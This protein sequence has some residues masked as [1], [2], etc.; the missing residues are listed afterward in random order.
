MSGARRETL[1]TMRRRLGSSLFPEATAP[2]PALGRSEAAVVIASLLVLAVILQL[3]R[4]GWSSS[5]NSLWAEDGPIFVQGALT[6]GFFH[7][8][9]HEY[10]GYLVLFPRLAGEAA[11]L[12][13][14]RDAPAVVSIL[15]ALAVGVSGVAVWFAA[16]GQIANPYLRGTLALLTVLAP[17]GGLETIDSASYASWY[18]LFAVFWLLLWRPRTSAGAVLA[19]LFILLTGLSNP[20]IWFFLPL[21]ALRAFAVRDRRD[22]AI[23]AGFFTAAVIQAAVFAGS[24]YEAVDPIWTG[25]IWTVLLQR[26]L[27]GAAFGLRLGGIG[28]SHLGWTLLIVLLVLGIA[29]LALGLRRSGWSARL[30][31]VI[32]LPTAIGMFV[33]SVYQRAVGAAMLWP[34]GHY[35]G[36]A[37]RYS[38]VPALLLVSVAFA[39][40]DNLERRRGRPSL[41]SWLSLAAIGLIL[42]SVGVSFSAGDTVA[43]GTPTWGAA[44]DRASLACSGGRAAAVSLETSP[45]GF[46][47]QLPCSD[48]PAASGVTGQR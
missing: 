23:V 10:A 18:M 17:V 26:V 30:L 35:F 40:L 16:A 20:G 33:I 19:A 27:D 1:L 32:A 2:G 41:P 36:A 5:L 29:G 13:P 14:L 42:V 45:P 38:I 25:D 43:R 37:G 9:G 31:A 6:G 21:A 12:F 11:A 15:S 44:V 39:F 8:L 46:G 28:W 24:S 47:M 7:N 3:L 4:I 22:A 34:A 48:I